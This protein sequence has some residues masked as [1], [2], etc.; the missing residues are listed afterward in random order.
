[1]GELA[2]VRELFQLRRGVFTAV[3][4]DGRRYLMTERTGEQVGRS[5]RLQQRLL[6]RLATGPAGIEELCALANGE[7][8]TVDATVTGWRAGGWLT[9]TVTWQNRRLYTIVPHRRP[10]PRPDSAPSGRV[11]SRLAIIR[12]V[13]R[14]LVIESPKAWCDLH[15]HDAEL[16][17][18][19]VGAMAGRGSELL[20]TRVARALWR[21]LCWAGIAVAPES[22]QAELRVRQWYAHELWF[23]QRTRI[24]DRHQLGDADFAGTWWA[25]GVYEPLPARPDPFPGPAVELYRP[26][27]D[28]LRTNDAPLAAV[29]EDRRSIREHDDDHPL[30]ADQLG[31]LLYRSARTRRVRA[32]QG[33]EF[34]SRP[35]PNGGSFYELE[36]YPVVHRVSGLEP[37]MYHYDPHG[38]R[39]ERVCEPNRAT[40]NL[41]EIARSA[42]GTS[43]LPQLLLVISARFGRV[44]W[45]YE[46]IAYALILKHVGVL[47]QTI[48][49]TATAMGLA[50]CGLGTGDADS[51]AEATG[52]DP[53]V[54]SSVGEV[55][56]G[57]RRREPADPPR[58]AVAGA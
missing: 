33:V 41:L 28:A 53:L 6:E 9:V 30:R 44:M 50:P 3:A 40:R 32:D 39:L 42:S 51:F 19:V 7:P 11:L 14:D 20:P 25:R 45:K 48:Y 56:L 10:P 18:A 21:D 47:Y 24:G 23:H 16:L 49:L 36:L 17:P 46:Q 15:I 37:G 55:L 34:Q 57:S 38:H 27:V 31:E 22:E 29:V 1:V 13:A 5:T 58:A 26:D 43:R 8:D 2:E 52:R 4:S 35:Y 12:R 54:E